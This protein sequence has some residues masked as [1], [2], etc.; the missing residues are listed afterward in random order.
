LQDPADLAAADR[1]PLGLGGVGGRV[2]RPVRRLLL[3]GRGQGAVGLADKPPR[4]VAARQRDDLAALQLPK[5]PRPARAGQVAQAVEAAVVEAVQPAVGGALVAA[6]LG[7]DLADLGAV[8]AQGD[9]AGALVPARR[10][11]AG[12]GEP[13]DAA[14]LGAVGGWPGEQRRR[15][16]SLLRHKGR[17]TS[18][19]PS[20]YNGLK[21][22]S[23]SDGGGCGRAPSG[24]AG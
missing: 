7:G 12:V 2:K 13:A 15:H 4:R 19:E 21:E 3:V 10:G 17:N 23:T 5:P 22:R 11:V 6:E 8:P 1:N 14:L 9:D 16:G 20:S 24:H 18:R